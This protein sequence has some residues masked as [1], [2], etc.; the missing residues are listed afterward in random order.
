MGSLTLFV[1]LR[2]GSEPSC[3]DIALCN[4]CGWTL[5]C[6]SA[7]QTAGLSRLQAW[8]LEEL[9]IWPKSASPTS[10][11][12]IDQVMVAYGGWAEQARSIQAW[13][14]YGCGHK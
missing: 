7:Q 5:G 9:C 2:L 8:I 12:D 13:K 10:C 14:W 4:G 1:Q 11:E 3:R 6:V